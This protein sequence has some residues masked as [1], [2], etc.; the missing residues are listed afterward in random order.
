ME[1]F[2]GLI[3]AQPW[4][5]VGVFVGVLLRTLWPWLTK[6]PRPPFDGKAVWLAVAGGCAALAIVLPSMQFG[7]WWLAV[8][9]GIIAGVG[10]QSA[11]RY[12]L[13]M[14]KFNK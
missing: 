10:G 8:L 1:A 4:L 14:L 7:E 11:I 3:Q 2:I 13:P 12:A 5:A 9:A 6:R